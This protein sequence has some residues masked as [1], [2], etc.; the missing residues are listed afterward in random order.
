MVLSMF[1]DIPDKT[2]KYLYNKCENFISNLQVGEEEEVLSEME[3]LEKEEQE[4]LNR[5]LKSKK[6]KKK[7]KNTNASQRNFLFIFLVIIS[8]LQAYFIFNYFMS[9]QLMSNLH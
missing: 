8:I 1:L 6:K 7:F 3:D 5:T 9:E 2:V 4:E